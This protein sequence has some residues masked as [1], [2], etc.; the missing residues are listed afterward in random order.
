MDIHQRVLHFIGLIRGQEITQDLLDHG[1]VPDD[2]SA[3]IITEVFTRG[4]CGNFAEALRVA[5][6]GEVMKVEGACHVVCKIDDR[7]YDVTGDV[8]TQYRHYQPVAAS[9][10]M[11]NY[12]FAER[13]PIV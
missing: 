12:S 10:Y 7:L 2:S 9:E 8:T 6:G 5:F 13:G 1:L 4:N 11:D 3:P